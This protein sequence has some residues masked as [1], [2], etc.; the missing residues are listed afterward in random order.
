MV[1]P[2]SVIALFALS[3]CLAGCSSY[4]RD[5]ANAA[6]LEQQGKYADALAIYDRAIGRIPQDHTAELADA[7]V[8]LGNCLYQTERVNDAFNAFQKALEFDPQNVDANLHIAELMVAAGIAQHALPYVQVVMLKQPNNPAAL[9]IMG[10][11]R[12]SL[13]EHDQAMK[14]YRRA[15]ALDPSRV[16]V[17]VAI[18][19]LYNRQDKVPESRAVLSEA[20]ARNPRSAVPWLALGRLEEQEGDALAAEKDYRAAAAADGT[21][22]TNLRLAQF[23]Q[24]T[25][26][27][28]EAEKVLAKV[29][30]MAPGSP[31]SLGDFQLS[32]GRVLSALQQYLAALRTQQTAA[33]AGRPQ[34]NHS[35]DV[36]ALTARAV[37]AQ[38]TRPHEPQTLA[39]A[40][41]LLNEHR[42]QLDS[43]TLATLEAEIALSEGGPVLAEAQARRAVENAPDSAAAHYVLGLALQRQAKTADARAE[44]NAAY[45]LDNSHVPAR[46]ALAEL[47]LKDGESI[48]AEEHSSAVVRE[49]PANLRGLEV[50]GRVL[51]EQGRFDSAH[52]IAER[53][54]SVDRRSVGPR[55]LL[56]DIALRQNQLSTALLEYEKA[57]LLD[58]HAPE[59]LQGLVQVYRRGKFNKEMIHRMEKIAEAPPASAALMEIAGRLYADHSWN[60]DAVRA[61][62]RA[63]QLD[64]QR[65]SA[66][67]A[68]SE[69]YNNEKQY[70]SAYETASHAFASDPGQPSTLSLIAAL[71]AEQDHDQ[72][73]A[74]RNYEAAVRSGDPHGVAANN[75]A[76]IYAT[77]GKKLD[78]A[79]QLAELARERDPQNAAI[80][81]TLGVVHIKRRNFTDAVAVL[82]E[83][84]RIAEQQRRDSGTPGARSTQRDLYRHLADAYSGIGENRSA[85]AA[86]AK[87]A[88]L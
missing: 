54:A 5:L 1:A 19:E 70:E 61:L 88:A 73:T 11:V 46:L 28:E 42:A 66:T 17:S 85:A 32:S 35:D 50:Y 64:S 27:V 9:A 59:A 37:E 3:L 48:A 79:L 63:A 43:G 72:D 49:E 7:Y 29:D 38:L 78:R 36:A 84:I 71:R 16:N 30:K 8:H 77:N 24:R 87:A 76:W 65:S 53:A 41:R 52:A 26:Q 2:R 81:D 44:W 45:A 56:G 12:A 14:L 21:Q 69:A 6:R 23:L 74:V 62:R 75:L 51:M 25:A 57:V 39:A 58:P 83:G 4:K 60:E 33:G 40:R 47:E 31:T 22:A 18:A 10:S 67:L 82:L 13:G 68:L 34:P 80:V 15:L 55:I 86:R 20:A